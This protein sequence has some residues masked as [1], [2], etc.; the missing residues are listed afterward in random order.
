MNAEQKQKLGTLLAQQHVAVVSTQGEEWPTATVQA[1]AETPEFG[2]I[3]IMSETALKFQNLRKRPQI[4]LH[5][6]NRDK[7]D[8]T[9]L[10]IIRAWI[11]GVARE[12]PQG[13]VEWATS[14]ALFLQKNPFEAPFFSNDML[15]IVYVTP[16]RVSY[17]DGFADSFK[18]DV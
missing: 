16:K 2:L 10:Q 18:A 6:D 15:R 12:I 9:S 11:E 13:S 5:V 7:G 14:K 8:V 1:F 17:A 3:L 4:T